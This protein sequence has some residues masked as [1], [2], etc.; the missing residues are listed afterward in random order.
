MTEKIRVVRTTSENPDFIF[1]YTIFD[2]FLWDRYPEL[3]AQYWGN[4]VI[5]FNPDVIIIYLENKAVACGCIKKYND[6]TAELKRMFVMP[7]ARG[8]GL[9]QLI[10]N[11]LENLAKQSGFEILILE[12]LY[13]QKEAINLYRK[14]GFEIVD[15]YE[16][17]TD[18]SNSICMRKSII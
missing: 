5:E 8:M 11:E 15:N 1:L 17:Y 12:T 9:A 10:L 7:D 14:K 18:L 13:K 4:N 3:K 2:S 16:P 6:N